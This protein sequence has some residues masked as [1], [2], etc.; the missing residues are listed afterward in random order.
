MT[1]ASPI[2]GDA[3]SSPRRQQAGERRGE[4]GNVAGDDVGV[5]FEREVTGVQDY[6]PRVGQVPGVG[7]RSGFGKIQWAPFFHSGP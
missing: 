1:E 2:A 5:V 3:S 6:D 7:M 4:L